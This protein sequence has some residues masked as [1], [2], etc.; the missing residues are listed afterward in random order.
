MAVGARMATTLAT[1]VKNGSERE[2]EKERKEERED[3]RKRK[4]EEE[5]ACVWRKE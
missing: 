2:R 4:V 3:G 1:K 5:S